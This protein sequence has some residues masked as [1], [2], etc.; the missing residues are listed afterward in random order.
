[1]ENRKKLGFLM[2]CSGITLGFS[3]LMLDGY[4]GDFIS[5]ILVFSI[6]LNN[7]I[8]VEEELN[9]LIEKLK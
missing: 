5:I 8:E 6:L 4:L 7:P 1:M 3:Q 2:L 9:D